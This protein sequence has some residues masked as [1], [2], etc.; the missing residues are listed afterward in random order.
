MS[1]VLKYKK[2]EPFLGGSIKNTKAIFRILE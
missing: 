2:I 1:R